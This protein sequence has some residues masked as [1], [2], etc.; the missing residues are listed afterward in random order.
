MSDNEQL[1]AAAYPYGDDSLALPVKSIDEASAWQAQQAVTTVRFQSRAQA[2]Q[3]IQ[4]TIEDLE[5]AHD[6][7]R[8]SMTEKYQVQF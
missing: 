1:F 8:Q 2:G 5:T 6:Q 3:W 7:I 4:K